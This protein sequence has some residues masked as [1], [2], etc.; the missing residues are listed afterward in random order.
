MIVRREKKNVE[1][2]I[3][4]QVALASQPWRRSF[5]AAA[6]AADDPG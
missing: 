2:Q 3:Q 6:S 5:H 4:I 1:C